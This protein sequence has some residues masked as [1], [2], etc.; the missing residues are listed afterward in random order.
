MPWEV[1]RNGG[2]WLL[3]KAGNIDQF[4]TYMA[5]DPT[6]RFAVWV[7]TNK[8][9]SVTE[10]GPQI[11]TILAEAFRGAL[12]GSEACPTGFDKQGQ[13]TP[14]A[15]LELTSM[16]PFLFLCCVVVLLLALA[17]ALR[18]RS[19][20]RAAARAQLWRNFA[21]LGI[22]P[23]NSSL[24]SA[25]TLPSTGNYRIYFSRW[26]M[27]AIFALQSITNASLWISFAPIAEPES[28]LYFGVDSTAINMLSIV[29]MLLYLPGSALASYISSKYGLR[30]VL[31]SA[32]CANLLSGLVRY[33]SCFLPATSGTV[34]PRYAVLLVGQCIGAMAQPFITNIPAKL[35]G[36]WFSA[37]ERELA[38]VIAALSNPIGNALGQ[39]LPTIFVRSTVAKPA[40]AVDIEGMD[41]LLFAEMAMSGVAAV[42]VFLAFKDAPPSPPSHSAS[43]RASLRSEHAEVRRE[44]ALKEVQQEVCALLQDREFMKLVLGFGVGLGLFNAML[45]LVNQ[46]VRP[47]GYS[48]DDAGLFGATLIGCGVLGAAGVG[49]FM[50]ATHAYRLTLKSGF[51]ACLISVCFMLAMLRPHNTTALTVA[52]GV[53]GL[54]MMPLYPV[55]LEAAVECTYPIAEENSSGVSSSIYKLSTRSNLYK[56]LPCPSSLALPPFL[57]VDQVLMIVGNV[58]GMFLTFALG[59]LLQVESFVT[60]YNRAACFMIVVLVFCSAVIVTFNGEYRRLAAERA[61]GRSHTVSTCP[62]ARKG[63]KRVGVNTEGS[64]GVGSATSSHASS[65]G[66]SISPAAA[67]SFAAIGGILFGMD[68]A[69]WA[70]AS[71]KEDFLALFCYNGGYGS[72]NSCIS[73]DATQQSA[74]WTRTTGT[75]SAMLQVGAAFSALVLGPVVARARGRRECIFAGAVISTV[76]M[77]CMVYSTTVRAMAA[78]RFL[79]GNGIGCIT[80]SLSMYIA[81]ISPKEERGQLGSLMQLATVIGVVVAAGINTPREWQWQ[82][83]FAAPIFPAAL[84][85]VGVLFLPES[86][87]WLVQCGR[88]REAEA[89]LMRL[90]GARSQAAV[91]HEVNEIRQAVELEATASKDSRW[92]ELLEPGM[93]TRVVAA[94]G[95][96]WCQQLSGINSVI[97][98]GGLFFKSA[99]L[100]GENAITGTLLTDAC[101]L[102]GTVVMLLLVDRRGRRSLLLLSAATMLCGWL[103]VGAIG[104]VAGSDI[105]VSV[106]WIVVLLV[107]IFQFGFG[108]GWGAIPWLYP[109]EIF[110]MRMK[111]KGLA[112]SVANQYLSNCVLLQIFP[113]LSHHIGINGVCFVFSACLVGSMC[114]VHACVPETSG[115]SLEEISHVFDGP[116]T[117]LSPTR[118]RGGGGRQAAV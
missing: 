31:V 29:F 87:R 81:E 25:Q 5:H 63:G 67:A 17:A 46:L 64:R 41:A 73:G 55:T 89:V 60:I 111:E 15:H 102:A 59:A 106:G 45:T 82:V 74:E 58:I 66:S 98:F 35:A 110:P 69:N 94:V 88:V 61:G 86:P 101:N 95:L 54:T 91:A 118:F 38:T 24:K 44:E 104:A 112:I 36:A 6:T 22:E 33:L 71:N 72:Y 2:Q 40:A 62:D 30:A 76:G 90:R 116:S 13:R 92:S 75:M 37:S 34:R 68:L 80:F 47:A 85:A 100:T 3:T 78:A 108:L 53:M 49:V 117:S 39:V 32:G 11:S 12:I 84:V 14:H 4:S 42:W 77:V 7:N 23:P 115:K 93:R 83:A 1:E 50:D 107:C 51:I 56:C 19:H 52:F 26:Q 16:A 113:V 114:F 43:E 27:L 21:A 99:G 9:Q 97:T 79:T 65:L 109:S 10:L 105:S 57:I 103:G 48:S 18:I 20:S 8:P 96:Q 70:G 28:T